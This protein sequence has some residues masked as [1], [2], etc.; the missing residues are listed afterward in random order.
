MKTLV[1]PMAECFAYKEN[2]SKDEKYIYQISST[3][4]SEKIKSM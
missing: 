4:K 3:K 2:K 1:S